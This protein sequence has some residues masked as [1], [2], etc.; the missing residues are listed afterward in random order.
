MTLLE[1]D[2]VAAE[3]ARRRYLPG[4]SRSAWYR[5]LPTV[6]W[7]I[8][9]ATPGS[10]RGTWLIS[11]AGLAEWLAEERRRAAPK[12]PVLRIERGDLIDAD[13][14]AGPARRAR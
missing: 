10:R 4:L 9:I 6:E 8:H 14:I 12:T 7:A 3:G 5:L 11:I 2:L 13:E 1:G